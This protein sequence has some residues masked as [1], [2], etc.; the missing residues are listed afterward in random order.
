MAYSG[1]IPKLDEISS[2]GL[3][4]LEVGSTS[5]WWDGRCC[6]LS[7]DGVIL[8]TCDIHH[9]PDDPELGSCAKAELNRRLDRTATEWQIEFALSQD[10]HSPS[11]AVS[12]SSQ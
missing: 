8:W 6:A 3:N 5:H 7:R 1:E 4:N 9:S 10:P 2:E 11:E 12:Q